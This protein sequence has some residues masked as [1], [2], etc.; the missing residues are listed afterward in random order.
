MEKDSPEI[1]NETLQ[2]GEKFAIRD[3]SLDIPR[4][5]FPEK[6]DPNPYLPFW[7]ISDQHAGSGV[8]RRS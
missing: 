3:A 5:G 4:Y 2:E 6:D 8:Q 7:H 1:S